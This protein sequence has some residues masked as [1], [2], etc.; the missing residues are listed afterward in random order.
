[1]EAFIREITRNSKKILME[2][3]GK[4]LEIRLKLNG[5]INNW[6]HRKSYK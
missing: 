5:L 2:M 3:A 1:M 4:N 6:L